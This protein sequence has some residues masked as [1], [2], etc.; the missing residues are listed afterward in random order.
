[1]NSTFQGKNLSS[2]NLNFIK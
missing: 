2:I 1:M